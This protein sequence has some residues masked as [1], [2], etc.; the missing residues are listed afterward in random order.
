MRALSVE[1]KTKLNLDAQSGPKKYSEAFA[2]YYRRS[3]RRP[4]L[5]LDQFDDYQAQPRYRDRFFPRETG[6]WRTAEALAK[7][8]SFW[9]LIR[10]CLQTDILT[11][12]VACREDAA[13]GLESF[14][15][16]P[17]VPQ[18]GLLRLEPGF[19][20]VI[21]DRLTERPPSQ[22]PVIADPE[23]GWTTLRD[24]MV[25]ELEARGQVLPQQLKV[26]IRGLSTLRR[27][28]PPHTPA[29]DE[30]ADSKPGS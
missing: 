22:P 26:V 16:H 6:V 17:D 24:R 28:L 20:R 29:R 27:L 15:F 18:F 25:D 19:I 14:R 7:E 10:H 21:I 8:N 2:D 5:M 4:L 30:Q 13:A 9:R 1:D 11:V 23:G 12:I 3:Q